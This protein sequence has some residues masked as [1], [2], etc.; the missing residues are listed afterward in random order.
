MSTTKQLVMTALLSMQQPRFADAVELLSELEKDAETQEMVRFVRDVPERAR[1]YAIETA[2][3]DVTERLW[4]DDP[5]R[6]EVVGEYLSQRAQEG[7]APFVEV[8]VT[9]ADPERLSGPSSSPDSKASSGQSSS[10]DGATKRGGKPRK[11]YEEKARAW[12]RL[13]PTIKELHEGVVRLYDEFG[14]SHEKIN[15]EWGECGF[16]P[17][18]S[19]VR[20]LRGSGVVTTFERSGNLPMREHRAAIALGAMRKL[21]E[22]VEASRKK[23]VAPAPTEPDPAPTEPAPPPPDM[24]E[25][26][27]PVP[28]ETEEAPQEPQ[29]QAQPRSFNTARVTTDLLQ[30]PLRRTLP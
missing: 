8:P 13:Q 15:K 10:P 2:V 23:P 27:A 28:P 26:P 16:V 25:P 17:M 3:K 18:T 1:P 22:R 11:S 7:E 5:W 4:M 14:M 6:I 20:T 30:H 12:A 9:R 19:D 29:V 21:L 24:P